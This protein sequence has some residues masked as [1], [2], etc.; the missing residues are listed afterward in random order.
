MPNAIDLFPQNHKV[1]NDPTN[2]LP[3]N[4]NKYIQPY[5]FDP[6]A[7]NAAFQATMQSLLAG[8]QS[9][10]MDLGSV[11]PGLGELINGLWNG[12]NGIAIA[13]GLEQSPDQ[14][15]AATAAQTQAVQAIAAAVAKLSAQIASSTL[16]HDPFE[17]T[18]SSPGS[19]WAVQLL[20]PPFIGGGYPYCDGAQLVWQP[21]GIADVTAIYRWLGTNRLA[22][23]DYTENAIVLG[24]PLSAT[25]FG[26]AYDDIYARMSDDMLTW[27]RCRVGNEGGSS[28]MRMQFSVNGSVNEMAAVSIP[29]SAAGTTVRMYCGTSIDVRQFIVIIDNSTYV[30]NDPHGASVVDPTAR[31]RGCGHFATGYLIGGQNQPGSIADWQANDITALTGVSTSYDGLGAADYDPTR[32]TLGSL[33]FGGR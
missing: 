30:I 31:G 24:T 23:T 17:R 32:A 13:L 11:V 29:P 33:V 12:L 9:V 5:P 27:T 20:T 1:T 3:V 25:N 4:V 10:G 6:D 28:V 26:N 7:A 2:R 14:I 22:T 19:N 8:L 18:A 16:A 21:G 15:A